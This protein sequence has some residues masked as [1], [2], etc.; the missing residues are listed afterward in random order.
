MNLQTLIDRMTPFDNQTKEQFI[1]LLDK[2]PKLETEL[3]LLLRSN[4]EWSN[5]PEA[6]DVKFIINYSSWKVSKEYRKPPYVV[7]NIIHSIPVVSLNV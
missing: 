7:L 6:S 3:K 1:E 2:Y 5:K 4:S